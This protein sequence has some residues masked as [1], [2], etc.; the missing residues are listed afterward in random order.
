M[1]AEGNHRL[2]IRFAKHGPIRFTSHRD[3]A[4]VWERASAPSSRGLLAGV[5]P[6]PRIS[7][8]LALATGHESTAEYLDVELEDEVDLERLPLL[9]AVPD[10]AD[11]VAVLEV[12]RGE[13][14]LQ[15]AVTSC[16]WQFE[17]PGVERHWLEAVVSDLLARREIPIRRKRKGNE[18]NADLR[19]GI[20]RLRVAGIPEGTELV[21][22]LNTGPTGGRPGRIDP[23][24]RRRARPVRRAPDP[25]VDRARRRAPGTGS[26]AV[27]ALDA[28][29]GACFMREELTHVRIRNQA[30]GRFVR[31]R[32]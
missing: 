30:P 20:R 9:S 28:R 4:R 32:L 29:H 3:L 22:E 16:T 13:P 27:A 8:G 26:R 2:R 12:E 7:F 31:W 21:A 23:R 24:R 18:I 14:S 5:L 6:H 17:L 19:P 10:G 11:A 15:E 1:T 25:S